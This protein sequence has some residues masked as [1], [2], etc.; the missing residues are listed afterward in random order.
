MFQIPTVIVRSYVD[1]LQKRGV[2]SSSVQEYLKWLRYYLDFCEKYKV[3]G[4]KKQ[5]LDRFMV[6]RGVSG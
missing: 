2:A 3:A 5:R 4:E 1:Y 6:C